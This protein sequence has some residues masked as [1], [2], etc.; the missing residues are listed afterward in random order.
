MSLPIAGVTGEHKPN[1]AWPEL[2]A[3]RPGKQPKI[4]LPAPPGDSVNVPSHQAA[5][6]KGTQSFDSD[7]LYRPIN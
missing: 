1:L 6:A 3:N 5:L 4:L 7:P 2:R